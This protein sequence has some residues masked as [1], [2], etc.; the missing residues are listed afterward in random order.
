MSEKK[1]QK[2]ESLKE[3]EIVK[4]Q[5]NRDRKKRSYK[6][7]ADIA[8][9]IGGIFALLVVIDV[10]S[11]WFDANVDFEMFWYFVVIGFVCFVYALFQQDKLNDINVIELREKNKKLLE[12]LKDFNATKKYSDDYGLLIAID[13]NTNKIAIKLNGEKKITTYRY[14]NILSCEII[15]DGV[16]IYKKST[17]RT[18]G[19]AVLG[20]VIAGGAG[21]IVGGLSGKQSKEKEYK[22]IQ[23]KL[24]I[25]DTQN[26]N[27]FLTF[28]DYKK[29]DPNADKGIKE[30]DLWGEILKNSK[31]SVN[32]WKDIITII[33]DK[34]DTE[35][36]SSSDKKE[37][38]S[39]SS[40]SDELLKLNELKEKGI[41]TEEE[42]NEQKKKLLKQ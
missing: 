18:V 31:S 34:I 27:I 42:F 33:I 41:L 6:Q 5:Q 10:F 40:V 22:K 23:L 17:T 16:S 8:L 25:K 3:L 4:K 32:E 19:G 9:T 20:G 39:N 1:N 37:S 15:E 38:N 11:W 12:N 35:L 30:S 21:A 29:V 2:E 7:N 24:L 26:P 28:F 13:D 36:D 14:N